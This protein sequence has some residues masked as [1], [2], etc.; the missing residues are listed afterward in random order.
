MDNWVSAWLRSHACKLSC[1]SYLD[2]PATPVLVH[3]NYAIL[4]S[5]EKGPTMM[6]RAKA[7][8]DTIVKTLH[9]VSWFSY[10]QPL[11]TLMILLCDRHSKKMWV[12]WCL[13]WSR[14][15]PW[16]MA[17]QCLVTTTWT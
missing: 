17:L 13:K 11:P 4:N 2:P 9:E 14:Q 7:A 3:S 6:D 10:K 5:S 15:D 16:A 8:M 12:S 1:S